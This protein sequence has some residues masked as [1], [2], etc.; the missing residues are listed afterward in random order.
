M[1][2][3]EDGNSEECGNSEEGEYSEEDYTS[4]LF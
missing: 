1:K 4:V 2:V 3:K